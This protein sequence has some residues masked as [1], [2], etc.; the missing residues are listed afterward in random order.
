MSLT[1]EQAD[2]IEI[3]RYEIHCYVDANKNCP[4]KDIAKAVKYN[5]T[6]TNQ[7]LREL[8][9]LGWVSRIKNPAG[10]GYFYLSLSE[11]V[12]PVVFIPEKKVGTLP[13]KL[14]SKAWLP[15]HLD[16]TA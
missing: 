16:L 1:K 8:A 5:I 6:S 15:G 7:R 4:A 12:K 3:K 13:S 11:P 14:L 10:T 9:D 2:N